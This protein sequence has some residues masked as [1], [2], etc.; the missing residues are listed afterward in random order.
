M[1]SPKGAGLGA[2]L[3]RRRA[4]LESCNAT[5]RE[6]IDADPPHVMASRRGSWLYRYE[7]ADG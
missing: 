5:G 6:F 3:H 7:Y 2:A 4:F 1:A